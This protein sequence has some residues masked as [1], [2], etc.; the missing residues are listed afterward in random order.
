M[1][2]DA[3]A[4]LARPRKFGAVSYE[5]FV[6]DGTGWRNATLADCLTMASAFE[7]PL[8]TLP[9]IQGLA[10]GQVQSELRKSTIVVTAGF[11]S[12]SFS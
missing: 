2:R 11:V 6:A 8:S 4:R 1:R 12:N 5:S 3:Y 9:V 7:G 10:T